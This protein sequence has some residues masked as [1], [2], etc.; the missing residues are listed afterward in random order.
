V[1]FIFV[2]VL[3]LPEGSLSVVV[4]AAIAEPEPTKSATKDKRRTTIQRRA[5]RGAESAMD[6]TPTNRP[7]LRALVPKQ[8]IA[9][10]LLLLI[11]VIDYSFSLIDSIILKRLYRK[12]Y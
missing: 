11:A 8:K 4:G 5:E 9:M 1:K 7:A 6:F 10:P 12:S 3:T 2:T